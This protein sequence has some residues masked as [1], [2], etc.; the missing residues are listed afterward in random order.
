MSNTGQDLS[1]KPLSE[2]STTEPT[3]IEVVLPVVVSLS[4]TWACKAWDLGEGQNLDHCTAAGQDYF[5][6][7][8]Q[9]QVVMVRAKVPMPEPMPE[10]DKTDSCEVE[11]G[12]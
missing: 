2:P 8:E 12:G 5:V 6:G 4:G 1:Q 7:G 3:L 11:L 10:P 9:V